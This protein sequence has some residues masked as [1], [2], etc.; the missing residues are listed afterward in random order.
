MYGVGACVNEKKGL[1][2]RLTANHTSTYL[3]L[4]DME[5]RMRRN[6]EARMRDKSD[7]L[8]GD[9]ELRGTLQYILLLDL[10]HVWLLQRTTS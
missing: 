7:V 8:A 3:I 2:F 5:P 9:A 6:N 10:M 4:V 1:E